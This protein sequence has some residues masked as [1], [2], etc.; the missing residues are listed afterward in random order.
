M[1]RILALLIV[2]LT[3]PLSLAMAQ[4]QPRWRLLATSPSGG[5]AGRHDD[6][7]FT[8]STVGWVVNG[9]RKV[10]KTTNGGA[11]WQLKYTAASYLRCVGFADSLVGWAGS[12]DS[13]HVL[14]STTDG[15]NTWTEVQNFPALR[16]RGVCGLSVVSRQVVYGSGA[17]FGSPRALK[18]TDGGAT[19]SVIDMRP[20]A[21]GLVDCFFFNQDSGFVVGSRGGVSSSMDTAI[22]LF[23]S[24]GG[25]TWVPK[26]VGLR[27]RELSWKITFPSSTIGYTSIERFQTG[28]SFYFRT[29]DRGQTW[30]ERSFVANQDEQGIGFTGD[31]SLG[32]IG[33]WGG[34]TYETTNGGTSWHPAGFGANVNRFRML[35]DTLG[36][37]VGE[38]VYKYSR[39]STVSVGFDEPVIAS[40]FSLA[41]NY[42]N[43]FNPTS[44]IR[45]VLARPVHVQL[46]VYD[47]L[48]R[49]VGTLVD[50]NQFPG[51]HAVE[52]GSERF[53]SGVYVYRLVA[54][55]YVS[56]KK[57]IVVK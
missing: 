29:T 55:T 18:T 56:T 6:I 19:W 36:Y 37:A 34:S 39:D 17:Y 30:H 10:Y 3:L 1:R 49:E 41:Q 21:S 53:A 52:V 13:N 8:S 43:P 48:G 5:N 27:S 7:F 11:T 33:G 23:T 9:E 40:G 15:G 47:L 51:D 26:I 42:P 44:H 28:Q 24:N 14:Y 46:K 31:T 35:S 57:M 16:P 20:Y 4:G 38:R 12:L 2:A 50:E 25:S 45:Y 54:G 22:V 32:W